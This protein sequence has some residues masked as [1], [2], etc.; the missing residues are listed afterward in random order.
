MGWAQADWWPHRLQHMAAPGSLT[1]WRRRWLCPSSPPWSPVHTTRWALLSAP[2]AQWHRECGRDRGGM[3]HWQQW[4]SDL[5][6]WT[7][8]PRLV[9]GPRQHPAQWKQRGEPEVSVE[10]RGKIFIRPYVEH[11]IAFDGL[12]AGCTCCRPSSRAIQQRQV[13]Q[14]LGKTHTAPGQRVFF[15]PVPGVH[16]CAILTLLYQPAWVTLS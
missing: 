3:R 16:I 11:S 15:T 10:K 1:C 4:C 2:M 9:P 13:A 14:E 5:I 12:Y 7:A 6:H 8:A